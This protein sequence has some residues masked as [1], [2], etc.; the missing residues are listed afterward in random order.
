MHGW[1][2]FYGIV[3][4]LGLYV[5]LDHY[6]LQP[7]RDNAEFGSAWAA[8]NAK[9]F[10]PQEVRAAGLT[11]AGARV[12]RR[13]VR[14]GVEMR[15]DG[16]KLAVRVA[17]N[18]GIAVHEFRRDGGFSPRGPYY[19]KLRPCIWAPTGRKHLVIVDQR[20]VEASNPSGGSIEEVGV[21]IA[22]WNTAHYAPVPL[23]QFAAEQ[24]EALRV[25]AEAAK[26][27]P[28]VGSFGVSAELC[29]PPARCPPA[30]PRR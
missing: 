13:V 11:P 8:S 12:A 3:A 5:L 7:R 23:R 22:E 16:G 24:R 27:V 2:A 17:S 29:T 10:A 14:V 6:V 4:C 30:H 1:L 15:S 19:V 28:T 21:Q 20:A 18:G 26:P 9:A 25:R